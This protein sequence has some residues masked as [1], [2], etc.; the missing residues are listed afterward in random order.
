MTIVDVDNH[1]LAGVI[2]MLFNHIFAD[3]VH[4]D[5]AFVDEALGLSEI[6]KGHFLIC[7]KLQFVFLKDRIVPRNALQIGGGRRLILLQSVGPKSLG[8]LHGF[9]HLL[10]VFVNLCFLEVGFTVPLNQFLLRQL[11]LLF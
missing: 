3:C 1:L 5:Q 10:P 4:Q 7:K 2:Q 8:V 9:K 11:Y 6:L